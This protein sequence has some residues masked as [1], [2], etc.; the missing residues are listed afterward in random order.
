MVMRKEDR[1]KLEPFIT[2]EGEELRLDFN[3]VIPKPD[4]VWDGT[5]DVD[6]N[7][8][9]ATGIIGTV[10]TG[11]RSGIAVIMTF[12]LYLLIKRN[13]Q[14]GLTRHGHRLYR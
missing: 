5:G 1:I 6:R 10:I 3:K 4:T 8:L 11:G 12:R 14:S 9:T 2:L 13:I 7:I